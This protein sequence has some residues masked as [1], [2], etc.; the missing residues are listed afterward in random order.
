MNTTTA[1]LIRHDHSPYGVSVDLEPPETL[2]R[3][4]VSY[5]IIRHDPVKGYAIYI[6]RA[7]K[8]RT[9]GVAPTTS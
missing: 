7:V 8:P 1:E 3:D 9:Q 4:G 5:R 6:E 2:E